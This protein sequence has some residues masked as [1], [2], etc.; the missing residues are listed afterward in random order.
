MK[1]TYYKYWIEH[2]AE[3][4]RHSIRQFLGA[5][6]GIRDQAFRGSFTDGE[7]NLFVY[8]IA[9]DLFLFVITKDQELIKTISANTLAHADIYQRLNV[10]EHIGFASYL[11]LDHDYLGLACTI[12]GPKIK[13]WAL[14]VNQMF[15]SVGLDD[16]IFSCSPFEAQATARDAV[17]FQFKSAIR[18]AVQPGNPLFATIAAWTG[19]GQDI[20]SIVVEVKPA[21]RR[22][23]RQSFDNILRHSR[24]Q[25]IESLVVRAKAELEDQLTD[26]FV[27]GSGGLSRTINEKAEQAICD[28][29]RRDIANNESLREALA[30]YR[31]DD[32]YETGPIQ[33]IRHFAD[34]ANWQPHLARH[35][36]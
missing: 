25:G 21:F 23:M 1:V 15:Q 30:E 8:H 9:H 14:F 31:G 5:F 20:Q 11:H 13:R 4:H 26:F 18:I 33:R 32:A 27:V 35:R 6:C 19:G 29:I 10:G 2:D 34:L 36:Q 7:D 24:D 17:G 16:Y 28:A 3:R 12:H 22:E